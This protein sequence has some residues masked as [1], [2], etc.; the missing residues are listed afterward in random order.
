MCDFI[1]LGIA[2]RRAKQT[3]TA[4]IS[5][6]KGSTSTTGLQVAYLVQTNTW[7][8]RCLQEVVRTYSG[9]PFSVHSLTSSLG[10]EL[11]AV[12]ET[13]FSLEMIFAV[14][15]DPMFGIRNR[16][17]SCCFCFTIF[18]SRACGEDL[19]QRLAGYI[20][21]GHVG[22]PILTADERS[23]RCSFGQSRVGERRA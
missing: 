6:L 10:T 7:R 15:G 5:A 17:N 21:A 3:G 2:N 1:K 22:A 13:M 14:T 11:C 20:D 16:W 9:R 4:P 12:V 19:L 23:K 8:A 18:F